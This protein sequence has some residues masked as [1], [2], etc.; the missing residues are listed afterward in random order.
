VDKKQPISHA[1]AAQVLRRAGY[2]QERIEE[3]LR[4]LPDPIDPERD[5]VALVKRGMSAGELMDRMGASP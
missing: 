2:S 5:G 3:L 4:D 1:D